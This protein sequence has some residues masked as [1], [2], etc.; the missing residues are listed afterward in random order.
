MHQCL[1]GPALLRLPKFVARGHASSEA[2]LTSLFFSNT[3]KTS[4]D[5]EAWSYFKTAIFIF[6]P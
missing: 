4:T 2:R 1:H 5:T 3:D 6:L